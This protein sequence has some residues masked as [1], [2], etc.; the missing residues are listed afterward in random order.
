VTETHTGPAPETAAPAGRR[1]SRRCGHQIS[2][3]A[4]RASSASA[5][6]VDGNS[7]GACSGSCRADHR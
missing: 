5:D 1:A 6:V 3:L 2:R 7:L 4:C